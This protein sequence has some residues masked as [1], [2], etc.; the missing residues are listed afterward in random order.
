MK[1]LI[2]AVA[3]L[4]ASIA[5]TVTAQSV[6]PPPTTTPTSIAALLAEHTDYERLTVTGYIVRRVEKDELFELRDDTAS[7]LLKVDRK[8]WPHHVEPDPHRRVQATGKFDFER[9]GASKLKVFD[10]R[11]AP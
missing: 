2:I 5:S 11:P 4:V 9:S 7:I 6:F 3:F 1:S 8:H 10:L